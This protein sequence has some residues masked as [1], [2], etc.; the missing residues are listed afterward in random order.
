[1]EELER[2]FL[3]KYLPEDLGNF[4]KKEMADVFIPKDSHHPILRIRKKGDKFEMTKKYPK[5]KGD[6]SV[7]IEETIILDENEFNSLKNLDGKEHSKTRYKYNHQGTECEIDIYSKNLKGL[8]VIDF[9]FNSEQEKGNFE[10]PEFCLAEVTNEEFIA[11][12][13]LCGKS[14]QDIENELK[15]YNY[16]KIT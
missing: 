15:K 2:T 3:A 5:T 4:P 12:G 13:F 9:E 7:M 11:G 8:V 14:Y 10:K 1:M 16:N 6:N